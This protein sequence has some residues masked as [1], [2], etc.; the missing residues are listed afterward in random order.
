VKKNEKNRKKTKKR[1][2]KKNPAWTPGE[3][4]LDAAAHFLADN[5]FAEKRLAGHVR[6][7]RSRLAFALPNRHQSNRPFRSASFRL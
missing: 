5:R 3:G 7:P 4:V 6:A 2:E 1:R